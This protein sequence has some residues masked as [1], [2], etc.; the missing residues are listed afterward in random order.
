VLKW[1]RTVCRTALSRV[2]QAAVHAHV[3]GQG[4]QPSSS[5]FAPLSYAS[6]GLWGTLQS[7]RKCRY[8]SS[9]TGTGGGTGGGTGVGDV[10]SGALDSVQ[11][12]TFAA[13]HTQLR[14]TLRASACSAQFGD[15]AFKRASEEH[16][17]KVLLGTLN[18]LSSSMQ[19]NIVLSLPKLHRAELTRLEALLHDRLGYLLARAP[20]SEP[21]S[22]IDEGEGEGAGNGGQAP[23]SHSADASAANG[24]A[25]RGGGGGGGDGTI[26]T[27]LEGRSAKGEREVAFALFSK[28]VQTCP[29]LS[30]AWLAWAE[31]QRQALVTAEGLSH[32]DVGVSAEGGV[33]ATGK[34]KSKSKGKGKGKDIATSANEQSETETRLAAG[35]IFS[36]LLAARGGGSSSTL[37]LTQALLMLESAVDTGILAASAAEATGDSGPSALFGQILSAARQVPG[38]ACLS[39]LPTLVCWVRS[40]S[41]PLRA[42]AQSLLTQV[43]TYHPQEV[44]LAL[45][46]SC[47]SSS[48]HSSQPPPVRAV[49]SSLWAGRGSMLDAVQTFAMSLSRQTLILPVLSRLSCRLERLAEALSD[50]LLDSESTP[51][52]GPAV[53]PSVVT[54]MWRLI[55]KPFLTSTT[56]GSS[57]SSPRV[58]GEGGEEGHAAVAELRRQ[59]GPALWLCLCSDFAT[60]A[61]SA[62]ASKG[63]GSK[64]KK[65]GGA[66]GS[67]VA[68]MTCHQALQRVSLWL[69]AVHALSS[70]SGSGISGT[71]A[72]SAVPDAIYAGTNCASLSKYAVLVPGMSMGTG[73]GAAFARVRSGCDAGSPLFSGDDASVA[74]APLRVLRALKPAVSSADGATLVRLLGSDGSVYT[75]HA[76]EGRAARHTVRVAA[77][78]GA[79]NWLLGQHHTSRSR[80]LSYNSRDGSRTSHD[81]LVVVPLPVAPEEASTSALTLQGGADE[82][83]RSLHELALCPPSPHSPQDSTPASASASTAVDRVLALTKHVES[84]LS[85]SGGNAEGREVRRATFFSHL[86][87]TAAPVDGVYAYLRRCA[88]SVAAQVS[89]LRA[90]ATGYGLCMAQQ[91]LL[92]SSAPTAQQVVVDI[93]GGAVML[94]GLLPSV[95]KEEGAGG[96]EVAMSSTLPGNLPRVRMTRCLTSALRSADIRGT[97]TLA[98]GGALDSALER[99]SVYEPVMTRLVTDTAAADELDEE[100]DEK[101]YRGQVQGSVSVS[102]HNGS[103]DATREAAPSRPASAAE[104]A[105]SR[106]LVAKDF[107]TAIEALAP[108]ARAA[109]VAAFAEGSL[110]VASQPPPHGANPTSSGSSEPSGS[111]SGSGL[112]RV[113]EG[114]VTLLEEAER[115]AASARAGLSWAPH[116]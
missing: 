57:T 38:W 2:N 91:L 44:A 4:Q 46:S 78:R 105:A 100:E 63:G 90:F 51:P 65:G 49:L 102:S 69:R 60:P 14:R 30:A 55:S 110:P 15:D 11:E 113:D 115:Q 108:A 86:R 103:H 28:S 12:E 23:S 5:P 66:G 75:F 37:M 80:D 87:E 114:L 39:Q 29:D 33:G 67:G 84:Y 81:N 19:S 59:L 99:L 40:S 72:P 116:I 16:A 95:E 74:S 98:L 92:G 107:R 70:G 58:D 93:S 21:A 76:T 94:R 96:A 73:E 77:A 41:T 106:H 26:N 68:A 50:A 82:A 61:A 85:I 32:R 47:P 6:E 71:R 48:P 34:S 3:P 10:L 13:I 83:Q 54:L 53:P 8:V 31:S 25:Q 52:T 62:P 88:P 18:R 112:L 43:G 20:A 89:V 17:R 22:T 101:E 7:A 42:L 109:A 24:G 56:T 79:L 111:G 104:I 1:R 9:S 36:Y 64:G 27:S 97:L 35:A 45:L